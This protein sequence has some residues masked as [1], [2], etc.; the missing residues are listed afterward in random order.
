MNSKIIILLI[1]ILGLHAQIINFDVNFINYSTNQ[2][3][4]FGFQYKIKNSFLNNLNLG[5]GFQLFNTREH[6]NQ[7]HTV[8]KSDY[9]STTDLTIKDI[10]YF[11]SESYSLPFLG[12]NI[13]Q[14]MNYGIL[15]EHLY[16]D[17][18][19]PTQI[20]LS[21]PLKTVLN[22]N[23][24]SNFSEI[25]F[26]LATESISLFNEDNH[27][28]N[29]KF[30]IMTFFSLKNKKSKYIEAENTYNRIYDSKNYKFYYV[31]SYKVIT[32]QSNFIKLVLSIEYTF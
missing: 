6:Y 13:V 7:T 5:A 18:E 25:G 1:T 21:Y 29:L 24:Q 17:M 12:L 20:Q 32:K 10:Y 22:K 30:I 14:Q 23:N 8:N 2:A 26:G 15:N 19:L 27:N 11:I 9:K 3:K 31:H 16:L 28:Q 4:G